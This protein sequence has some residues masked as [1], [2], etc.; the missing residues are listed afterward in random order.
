M[1]VL[2]AGDGQPHG[3]GAG[4]NHQVVV[5]KD[6]AGSGLNRLCLGIDFDHALAGLQ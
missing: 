1:H 5:F 3:V 4:G 6:A 2:G